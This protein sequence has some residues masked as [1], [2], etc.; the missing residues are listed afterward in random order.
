VVL[1]N[2]FTAVTKDATVDALVTKYKAL[3][4]TLAAQGVG[5]ITA[6]INR[7]TLSNGTR[8]ESTEGALGALMADSYLEGV[9]GGADIAFV[10]PGSVRA[11]LATPP[12]ER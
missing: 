5:S 1:P 4:A 9:P 6:S 7:A 2:G 8:D 12:P 11:D 10:N 3:S